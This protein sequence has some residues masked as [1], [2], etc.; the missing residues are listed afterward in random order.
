MCNTYHVYLLM[1]QIDKILTYLG[2]ALCKICN[3]FV[4][5]GV[6]LDNGVHSP[7]LQSTC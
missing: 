7:G 3:L 2:D 6:Q 4:A 5:R 1:K